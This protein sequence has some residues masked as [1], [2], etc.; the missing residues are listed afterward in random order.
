MVIHDEQNQDETQDFQEPMLNESVPLQRSTREMRSINDYIIFLQEQEEN[1]GIIEDDSIN[2]CQTM[3]N[4]NFKKLIETI[5]EE[6]KFMRDN[7]VWKLIPLLKGVKPICCKVISKT[8]QNSKSNI[9]R[10]KIC[11]YTQKLK[12][13]FKKIDYMDI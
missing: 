2:F 9:E 13:D 10:Y 7:K 5:N 4:S 11:H 3:Q 1:N 6:Y 8:K 12:I